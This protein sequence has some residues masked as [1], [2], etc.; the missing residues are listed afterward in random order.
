MVLRLEAT[1]SL[2]ALSKSPVAGSFV[3]GTVFSSAMLLSVTTVLPSGIVFALNYAG[4]RRLC[5][6]AAA[7]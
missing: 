4:P 5:S 1:G 6:G 2:A 3:R 7:Y